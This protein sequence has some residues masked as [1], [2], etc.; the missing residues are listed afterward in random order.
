HTHANF[1]HKT[2]EQYPDIFYEFNDEN[3]DYYGITDGASCPLCKL[4]HDDEEGI[5]AKSDKIL[6]SE[7]LDWYSKLTDLPTTISDKLRSKLY[8]IYKKKTGLDPWIK[9]KNPEPPQ[10]KKTDNCIL[11]DSSPETQ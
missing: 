2:L 8:K 5:E 1:R 3:I 11:Q 4:D 10:I 7:Y 9:Y 6:S